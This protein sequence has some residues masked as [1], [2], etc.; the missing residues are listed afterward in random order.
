MSLAYATSQLITHNSQLKDAP[1]RPGRGHFAWEACAVGAGLRPV[2]QCRRAMPCPPGQNR[3]TGTGQRLQGEALRHCGTGARHQLCPAPQAKIVAPA[4]GSDCRA[5]P[6]GTAARGPGISCALPP[7]PKS[8]HRHRAAIAGRSPAAL[9]H[10][11][12]ASAMPCPPGQN[13]CT[14]TGQRLQGE[15]LRHCGTGA[16]HQL[17]PAPQAKIVAPAPGSDCRAKPCGTAARGPGI[18]CALPPRPK[19]LH[20]HRAAIAGRSPAALRHGGQASAMP[21][22]PGQNRCTGTGQRL[23][24]EALRH[25]GTGARHQLCPAPQAE[26]VASA[27]GS[28]CRAKPC[29]TAAR[30][31]G[32]SYALPPRPKSLHRHRAAIAGRSPAALRHGAQPRARQQAPG[33]TKLTDF[34]TPNFPGTTKL[35]DFATPNFPG[36]TKLTNF[37]TPDFSGTM[38]LTD[39]ATPDFPGTTK[40]TN[41]ATPDFS[42]TMKLTDFATPENPATAP[43]CVGRGGGGRGTPKPWAGAGA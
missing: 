40:L 30:G 41:F 6:C 4:P 7:R 8:L 2:P 12:Q 17:C 14:G 22:P 33:T 25:C 43:W 38:K 28:D 24:G 20:R 1:G 37:A 23:Q 16:R 15:A 42:G 29:G 19:S 18:S 39:F 3:C 32:I 36:T 26:I 9:R 13:R 35:T 21:C 5:K 11:G 27:P 10:G 34:A 31:P